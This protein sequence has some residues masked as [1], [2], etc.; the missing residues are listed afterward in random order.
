MKQNK[1]IKVEKFENKKGKKQKLQ[2]VKL[3]KGRNNN[4]VLCIVSNYRFPSSYIFYRIK[5]SK[6]SKKTT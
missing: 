2:L 1:K 4:R 5:Y 6:D 3:I